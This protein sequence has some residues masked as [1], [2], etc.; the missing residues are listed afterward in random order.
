[1]E[2]I[3]TL[4]KIIVFTAIGKMNRNSLHSVNIG[5]IGTVVSKPDGTYMM[6]FYTA[7]MNSGS[8]IMFISNDQLKEN[9]KIKIYAIKKREDG[10]LLFGKK[11]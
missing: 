7:K 5:E 3:H 11:S 2:K 9:D 1:M 8:I 4:V 6:S 10:Y